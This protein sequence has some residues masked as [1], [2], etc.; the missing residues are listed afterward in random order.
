M[1]YTLTLNPAIDKMLYIGVLEKNITSRIKGIKKTIGGKGTHVSINLMLLGQP[2]GAFGF[3]HGKVGEEIINTLKNYGVNVLF[4]HYP[5]YESRTN[6]LLIE[7]TG[8]STVIAE[9][10]VSLS[11]KYLDDI[12]ET[13]RVHLKSG[14]F[15]ILSGDVSNSPDPFVYNKIINALKD[16]HLKIFL[17]TSG[18]SLEK[19]LIERP[20]L[21][22][23][24]LD[25]LSSLCHRP[26]ANTVTDILS[27]VDSLACYEIAVIA[28]SLG[29]AGALIKT[30]SGIYTAVPPKVKASNTVGCG[31]CFLSGLIYGIA[32]HMD[33]EKTLKLATAISAAAAESPLSVGFNSGRAKELFYECQITKIR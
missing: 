8:D 14:D 9:K 23:P 28:V 18:L 17:D 26:I 30:D 25:E 22:K 10:G 33:I 31:D 20:Y 1:I 29:K 5:E 24:N 7:E 27:A 32:N 21:I 11:Q 2:N 15:L 6:Y 4:N 12:I 3:S 16:K 19:C 13:M